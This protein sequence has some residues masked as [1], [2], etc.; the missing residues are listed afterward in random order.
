MEPALLAQF[1]PLEEALSA[2]GADEVTVVE[3]NAR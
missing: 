2:L 3:E 1:R